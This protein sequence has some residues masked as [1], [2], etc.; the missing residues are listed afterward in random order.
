MG[1]SAKEDP[2]AR[3]GAI[4][5][6]RRLLDDSPPLGPPPTGRLGPGPIIGTTG[7]D[8]LNGTAE[9]NKMYGLVGEPWGRGP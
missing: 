2:R 8:T 9:K 7:K 3:S 4:N 1:S 6:P 5:A